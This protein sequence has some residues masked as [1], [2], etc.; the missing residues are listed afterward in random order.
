MNEMNSGNKQVVTVTPFIFFLSL[1]N[2]PIPMPS[3][4]TTHDIP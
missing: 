2:R 3:V 4:T 1:V